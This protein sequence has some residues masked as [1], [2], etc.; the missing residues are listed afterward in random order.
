[1]TTLLSQVP[2]QPSLAQFV[3]VFSVIVIALGILFTFILFAKYFNLWIQA[4]MMHANFS[5]FDLIG[6]SLR[7]VNPVVI[8]R[9]KIMAIQAGLTEEDG[10]TTRGLEAHYLAGGDVP[11]VLRALI[12]ADRADIP[13]SF[14]EA[15]AIDLSGQ[16]V[17]ETVQA[18][19][20]SNEIDVPDEV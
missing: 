14:E 6:M 2:G 17:L 1:M 19:V 11:N 8:V 3:L 9:S 20:D 10:L 7:R 13:L 15:A 12:A 4:K 5:I 18:W 16:D